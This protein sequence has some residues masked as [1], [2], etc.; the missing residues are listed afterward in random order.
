MEDVSYHHCT[1]IQCSAFFLSLCTLSL[2]ISKLPAGYEGNGGFVDTLVLTAFLLQRQHHTLPPSTLAYVLPSYIFLPITKTFQMCFQ[3]FG[4]GCCHL[5]MVLTPWSRQENS[6]ARPLGYHNTSTYMQ[7]VIQALRSC[8][9][10]LLGLETDRICA[11]ASFVGVFC[12]GRAAM[13][14]QICALH[15]RT[16][17]S[18][19]N[20]YLNLPL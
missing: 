6:L 17:F 11:G 20:L 4:Q 15:L 3:A 2:V 14:F 12:G 10:A 13:S 1:A 8:I 7:Q 5:V 16:A 18:S 19:C 9:Q